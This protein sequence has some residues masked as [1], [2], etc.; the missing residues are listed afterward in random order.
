MFVA[1]SPLVRLGVALRSALFAPRG[2][3]AKVQ[4]RRAVRCAKPSAYLLVG[5]DAQLDTPY[6]K[7]S[8]S[9]IATGDFLRCYSGDYIEVDAAQRLWFDA[10]DISRAPHLAPVLMKRGA[11]GHRTPLRDTLCVA[12]AWVHVS[13]RDHV[14]MQIAHNMRAD[15]G[16]LCPWPVGEAVYAAIRVHADAR[17][18]VNGVWLTPVEVPTP[19]GAAIATSILGAILRRIWFAA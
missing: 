16:R 1:L 14:G 7:L 4:P 18:C 6:G 9:D 12:G 2:A 13:D 3:G 17:V 15:G 10:R 5:L 19:F 8:A 11:F